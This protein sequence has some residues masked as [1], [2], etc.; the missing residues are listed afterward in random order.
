MR[1]HPYRF[2]GKMNAS[3]S[4]E[5]GEDK[6]AVHE[7]YPGELS[8]RVLWPIDDYRR[9]HGWVARDIV[10]KYEPPKAKPESV[11]FVIVGR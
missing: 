9:V 5:I 3:Y 2:P 7:L 6:V 4:Y 8:V 10:V 11:V 1:G